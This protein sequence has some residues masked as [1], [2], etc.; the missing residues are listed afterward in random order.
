MPAADLTVELLPAR[1]GDCILVSWGTPADRHHLLVDAGPAFAYQDIAAQLQARSVTAVDLLVL[2]HIDA[3]HVEGTILL[4]NDSELGL[5]IGEVW[6]NGAP[7][8]TSGTLGPVQGEILGALIAERRLPWNRAFGGEAVLARDGETP[9]CVGFPAGL[10]VTVL[11]PDL[12]QL[13][14]LHD[15]WLE[16]CLAADLPVGSTA[17]A[18]AAL[19]ARPKLVPASAYLSAGSTP[20]V[21]RFAEQRRGNDT[22]V[23]NGSSIVLLLEWRDRSALLTGDATPAALRLAVQRLLDQRGGATLPVDVFKIPHH[24]SAK[25]IDAAI[26][27]LV[28]ADHY[29]IS[30]DG[31]YFN[32]PDD[33]AV[34]TIVQHGRPTG[35]LVFNYDNPRNRAWDDQALL[36][37]FGTRARYPEPGS[38]GVRVVLPAAEGK[39]TCESR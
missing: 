15:T 6:Y 29:L 19:R 12:T 5:E 30:T 27:R 4:V 38:A 26:A 34:A 39:L 24:G 11:G 18:L 22:R 33:T 17:A 9:R 14:R 25:N 23:A 37:T 7:Q 16:V 28:P 20:D 3:D 1:H 32:H 21:A 10:R 13:H 36:D 8:L 31:S 35:E 2:T